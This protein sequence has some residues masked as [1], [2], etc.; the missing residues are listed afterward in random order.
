MSKRVLSIT[1][2]EAVFSKWKRYVEEECINSSKLV[3]KLL[4]EHLDKRR[5]KG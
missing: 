5:V 3:E 4:R 2:D 1:I